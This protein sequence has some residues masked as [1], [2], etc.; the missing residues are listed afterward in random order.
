MTLST[1]AVDLDVVIPT[2]DRPDQLAAC[3][4]ALQRQSF[5]R[6]GVIVVDDG[7]KTE[8]ELLVP[9]R[10]RD[11]L[12]V[13]F[14]RNE[15][16]IGPGPSRNRGVAVSTAPYVV[17]LD[18]DCVADPNLIGRHRMALASAAWPIVSLGP[19]MSPPGTRLPAWT[20]WDA[21]RLEREYARLSTGHSHPRYTHL[22]TGNVGIRRA[23]FVAVGGFD[24]RFAQQEDIE[25]GYRLARL[26]CR[27]EFDPAAVVWHHSQRSLRT[28][29]RI[30]AA[31]ARFDVEMDRL[32]PDSARLS[33]VR[34]DLCSRHWALRLMRRIVRGQ[35]AH[36]CA[37]TGAIGTGCLF[38]AIRADRVALSAF[39]LVWDLT[40]CQ[41][42]REATSA[43]NGVR[44]AV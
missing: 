1:N 4:G 29:M 28:W 3:L 42:L 40:Y 17:L 35:V 7:G 22:Y 23:D 2:R 5:E 39:S 26:G 8:A 18:D 6:F 37:I 16:S 9:E 36:R 10:V 43:A 34:N 41:A 11:A 13:R 44:A 21:D 19:I 33:A 30:P 31:Y 24:G 12:T 27:F 15:T 14:I 32:V 25:L 38:H 20:H